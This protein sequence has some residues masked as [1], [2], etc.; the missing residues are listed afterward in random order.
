MNCY[1]KKR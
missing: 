1:M